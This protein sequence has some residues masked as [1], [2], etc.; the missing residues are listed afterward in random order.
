MTGISDR[1]KKKA[2][3]ASKKPR[4]IRQSESRANSLERKPWVPPA[5]LYAPPPPEGYIHRWVRFEI[6]GHEDTKNMGSRLREGFEPVRADEYPD[7]DCQVVDHGR[8][9]GVITNGGLVLCRLPIETRDERKAYYDRVTEGQ[10]EAVH[11]DLLKE[12][13]SRMPLDRP[14]NESKVVFGSGVRD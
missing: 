2:L 3:A 9:A 11:N 6:L 14:V 10:N 5:L 4:A 7:F 1:D 12:N 13:D 8:H